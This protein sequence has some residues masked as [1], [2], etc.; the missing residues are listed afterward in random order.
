[1]QETKK[2]IPVNEDVKAGDE[3]LKKEELTSQELHR[4]LQSDWLCQNKKFWGFKKEKYKFI[5]LRSMTDY[6]KT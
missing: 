6:S 4:N 3:Y 1:M 5:T 2:W